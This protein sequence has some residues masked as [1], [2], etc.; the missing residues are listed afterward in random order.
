MQRHRAVELWFQLPAPALQLP[1]AAMRPAIPALPLPV[2][3]IW[4]VPALLLGGR[5]LCPRHRRQAT[6]LASSDGMRLRSQ[7]ARPGQHSCA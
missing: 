5:L 7:A 6:R 4:C 2:L 3:V 1:V